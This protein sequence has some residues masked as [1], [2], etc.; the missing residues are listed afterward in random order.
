MRNW[1]AKSA[2]IA[3]VS[4]LALVTACSSDNEDDNGSGGSGGDGGTSEESSL[5]G[6]ISGAG[7]SSQEAAQ[8]AWQA[9]FNEL[10][11]D[12][13]VN[14]DPSGSG[15]GREQFTAGGTAF[16]GT[17]AY[18]SE[19][20]G[21]LAAAQEICGE[22]IEIPVYVSPIA[23]IFNVEGVD[24]LNLSPQTIAGIFNQEI[25][26]WNDE[27]IAADNPDAEL[28]DLAITPVNRSDDSGTTENFT[29]Y[30]SVTAPDAWPHEVSD[31]WPVSG[32]EAAQGT[33]GVVQAVTG[34]EGTIGYADA[35]Q[36]GD[37]GT[38]AVGVGE[39]FVPYSPEAAAAVL[40]VSERVEGRGEYDFAYDL[41]RD[42]TEGGA[43]PI[44]LVSYAM[45]CAT[46][47]DENTAELVREYLGYMISAEGQEAAAG[48]AG[49]APLSDALRTE[50]QAAVDAISA[51]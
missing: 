24:S 29:E 39:E 18:L 36:A 32:G 17:D 6:T 4:A 48:A 22:V 23:V 21:E 45:A 35:S 30:L 7:A 42:T 5:S 8:A 26:N 34:G 25:T 12:V 49:S 1:R 46:Y 15:A 27:A 40:E 2:A 3:A 37:L 28:P 10:H 51:G 38:V 16:G 13:T 11:P 43:Y 20:E 9:G 47:D 44:V 19:E 50:F 33:S 41:A 31:V 14:Y